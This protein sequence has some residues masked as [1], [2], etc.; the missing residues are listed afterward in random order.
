MMGPIECVLNC[1]RNSQAGVD[2]IMI[3][4]HVVSCKH[5]AIVH[6]VALRNHSPSCLLDSDASCII[7]VFSINSY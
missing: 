1:Y 5:D 4:N 6:D 7:D 2:E 3:T